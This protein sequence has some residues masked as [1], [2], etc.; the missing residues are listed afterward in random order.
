MINDILVIAFS[1]LGVIFTLL[2]GVGVIRMP[3]FYMRTSISTKAVT[4]GV[5]LILVA[6]AV[7]FNDF[8]VTSRIVATIVFII[9]TAPV[10]AHI[11]GRA[12]Y[13]AKV[14]LWEKSVIN[15]LSGKYERKSHTLQSYEGDH[16]IISYPEDNKD[17]AA[18][19]T[20]E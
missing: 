1:T 13:F 18:Y 2:A 12:A 5:G 16:Q 20:M 8:G 4:L 17:D 14:K 10:G 7:S 9:L 19:G 3:D 6:A 11:L 15:E